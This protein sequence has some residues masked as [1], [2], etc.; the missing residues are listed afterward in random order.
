[1]NAETEIGLN[2]FVLRVASGHEDRVRRQLEA[3]VKAK[4]LE[5]MCLLRKGMRLSV[6]PVTKKEWTTVLKLGGVTEKKK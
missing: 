2:W 5:E 1:M 6:Q 4:A 3:R